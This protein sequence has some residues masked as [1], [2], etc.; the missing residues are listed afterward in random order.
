MSGAS[1]LWLILP[2]FAAIF[3]AV[4]GILQNY[5]VDT[6]IPKRKGGSYIVTHIITFSVAILITLAIFGRSVF[7][8]PL[9][10][11][12]GIIVAGAIN[13]VG[14]IYFYRAL[15]TGDTV[16]INI[17]SEVGPLISLGL[18]VAVLGQSITTNQAMAFLFIMAAAL[19]IVFSGT[20]KK[21]RSKP[22]LTTIGLTLVSTFF[23]VL[24]D[25]VFI[26]FLN[27]TRDY[28]LFAQ[29]FF[30]FELGSLITTVILVIFFESWRE[31]FKKAFIKSKK[32][33][34]F[35]LA[36]LGD[37]VLATVA[38][39]L[40]KIG[41]IMSPVLALFSVIANVTKLITGFVLTLLL[42]KSFPK[43]I[44]A[45]KMTKKMLYN[46]AIAGFLI[47]IGVLMVNG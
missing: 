9:T 33:N 26:Y 16:D 15:Q 14:S 36:M 21:E 1:N 32:R 34:V 5:V 3:Y 40:Q 25:V 43:F 37:N 18:G 46:Y 28:T 2:I 38:E 39:I 27:G 6:A 23:S 12:L 8:I 29:S 35:T 42:G 11:A 47:V 7:M 13:V 45:K 24:S 44:H 17:Y 19:L 31:S 41:L 20:S 22:D 4:T 30:Y 10:N